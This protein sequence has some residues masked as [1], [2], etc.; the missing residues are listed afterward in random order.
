[1]A[2]SYFA[3]L[4]SF[5]LCLAPGEGDTLDK[6]LR[7]GLKKWAGSAQPPVECRD[8]LFKRIKEAETTRDRSSDQTRS[9][10]IRKEKSI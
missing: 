2:S 3:P 1:M 4:L 7:S 6:Y 5:F 10:M 8:T 9:T